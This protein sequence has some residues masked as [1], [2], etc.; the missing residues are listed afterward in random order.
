YKSLQDNSDETALELVR[1]AVEE[2]EDIYLGST[3]EAG[4]GIGYE[5]LL[6][7]ADQESL[8]TDIKAQYQQIYD[9][10]AGRTLITGDENLYNSIQALITLYKS[11]LFPVL[12]IQDADGAN[13]GD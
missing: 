7:A 3:S 8:D 11:D 5:D 2:M 10:I 13:D 12:N 4:D 6:L 9:Q 1:V